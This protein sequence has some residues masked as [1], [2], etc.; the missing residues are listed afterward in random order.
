M[1]DTC[2]ISELVNEIDSSYSW[3][4][5]KVGDPRSVSKAIAHNSL[6]SPPLKVTYG[7]TY[8]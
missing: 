2:E 5:Y 6:Q 8:L 3:L 1:G 4:L 7:L